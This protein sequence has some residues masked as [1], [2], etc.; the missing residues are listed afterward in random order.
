MDL[1]ASASFALSQLGRVFSLFVLTNSASVRSSGNPSVNG[2]R[3]TIGLHRVDG[4]IGSV[5]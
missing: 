4:Y 3:S 2:K 1:V 5:K